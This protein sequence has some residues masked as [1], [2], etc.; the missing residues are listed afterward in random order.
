MAGAGNAVPVFLN[1]VHSFS[2]A[3]TEPLEMMVVG[4]ARQK[5]ALDTV[6]VTGKAAR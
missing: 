6:E 3:G 2:N 5:W 1:E 4:V